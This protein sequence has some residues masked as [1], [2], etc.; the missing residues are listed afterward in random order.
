M[1]RCSRVA[2]PVSSFCRQSPPT[3]TARN[4]SSNGVTLLYHPIFIHR[5]IVDFTSVCNARYLPGLLTSGE[6]KQSTCIQ[7]DSFPPLLLV[8][9]SPPTDLARSV[10]RERTTGA[11]WQPI[12]TSAQSLVSRV[13][14]S[15]VSVPA[16][17]SPPAAQLRWTTTT[18]WMVTDFRIPRRLA[19]QP[20]V[21]LLHRK[22]SSTLLRLQ[23][24]HN[25][26]P[27]LAIV[28]T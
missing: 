1:S 19:R 12:H 24:Q 2:C 6:R 15:P 21:P 5:H 11:A 25:V 26:Y 17:T 7:H 22:A 18:L 4:T 14:Y 20:R 27:A 13:R 16:P 3:A 23:V 8:C 10:P 9:S 28:H